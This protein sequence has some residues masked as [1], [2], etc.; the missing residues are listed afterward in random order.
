[1]LNHD[2][3]N[4]GLISFHALKTLV[5]ITVIGVWIDS[6]YWMRLFDKTAFFINLLKETFSDIKAFCA[7]LTI[8]LLGVSNVFYIFNL[9]HE[10]HHEEVHEDNRVFPKYMDFQYE[11]INSVLFTYINGLGE[12]NT[13]GLQGEH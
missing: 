2:F 8:L 3:W 9:I 11:F 1:M 5:A 4:N 10:D 7:M 12:F 13:D 6:F